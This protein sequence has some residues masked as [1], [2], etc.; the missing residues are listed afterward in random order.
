MDT[1]Q[2]NDR[3]PSQFTGTTSQP[4][5]SNTLTNGTACKHCTAGTNILITSITC[6][7]FNY[8]KKTFDEICIFWGR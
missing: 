8:D 5:T 7:F 3:S 6:Y 1:G 4:F 2:T